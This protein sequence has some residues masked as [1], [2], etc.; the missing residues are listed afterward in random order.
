MRINK[1]L[2]AHAE[3]QSDIFK[4]MEG[5][6]NYAYIER[7]WIEYKYGI[8]EELINELSDRIVAAWSP[9]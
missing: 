1:R 3:K 6:R 2:I 8:P 4:M 5:V 7:K 9:E